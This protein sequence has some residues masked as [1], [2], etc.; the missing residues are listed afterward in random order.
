MASK[1]DIES[2]IKKWEGISECY[3][4]YEQYSSRMNALMPERESREDL[5]KEIKAKKGIT[6]FWYNDIYTENIKWAS[7]GIILCIIGLVLLK[8]YEYL[9]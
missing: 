3:E 6:R 2:E 8:L 7:I 4:T 5:V 1:N 9:F